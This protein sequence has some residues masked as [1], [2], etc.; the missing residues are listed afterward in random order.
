M[1]SQQASALNDAEAVKH[2]LV[3][4]PEE[5]DPRRPVADDD[6]AGLGPPRL[7]E[8]GLAAGGARRPLD[9]EPDGAEKE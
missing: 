6:I 5:L 9:V 1:S 8:L 7:V 4:E 2:A 3:G